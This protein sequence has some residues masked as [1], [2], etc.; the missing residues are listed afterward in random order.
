MSKEK[1]GYHKAN[2]DKG[3]YGDLSKIYEEIEELKDSENQ[4]NKIMI[5]VELSD[6][7]GAIEGYLEKHHNSL[8]L[9]DLIIMSETTKRAF[10][11][12]HRK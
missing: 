6:V 8:S 9:K 3:I 10:K 11:N 4:D 12:N 7:I 2:I 5:L 1:Y